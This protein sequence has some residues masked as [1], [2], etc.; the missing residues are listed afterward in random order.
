MSNVNDLKLASMKLYFDV[1][2]P[3]GHKK[4]EDGLV[5]TPKLVSISPSSGSVGGTVVTATVPGVGKST[6][7]LDIVDSAG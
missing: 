7:D 1:G 6:K 3:E 2:V 4:V 5:L